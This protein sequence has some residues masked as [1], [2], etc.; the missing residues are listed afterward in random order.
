MTD[1]RSTPEPTARRRELDAQIEELSQRIVTLINT[2]GVEHRQGLREYALELIRDG[3]EISDELPTG[4]PNTT[5]ARRGTNP[6]GMALLLG[7]A[8]LPLLLLFTPVGLAL[9]GV[10]LVLALW[11]VIATV[12]GR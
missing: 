3:T 5:D 6:I 7:M 12:V 10:A 9:L 11:G 4:A 1:E 8:S 2:G